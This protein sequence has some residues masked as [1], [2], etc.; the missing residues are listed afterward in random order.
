MVFD[1]PAHRIASA[2]E[3]FQSFFNPSQLK[4]T[5]KA[6]GFGRIEDLGSGEMN[7]R[8]FKGH[9]ETFRSGGFTHVMN[10]QIR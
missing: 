8:Y 9:P 6:M 4:S 5:L 7:A 3:P 10:A 2:G 1:R